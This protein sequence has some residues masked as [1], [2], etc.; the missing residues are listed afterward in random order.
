MTSGQSIRYLISEPYAL[1]GWKRLPYAVQNLHTTETRF[2]GKEAFEL[3]SS[4]NGIFPMEPQTLENW[5]KHT[6]EEWLESGLIRRAEP[7]EMLA[8]EQEYRFFPARFKEAVHWSVTGRCNYRCRHCFM[9]APHA[10][11]GEPSFEDCMRMLESFQR[12]GIRAI[13]LTGG[14][15]L[16]RRDFWQLVDEI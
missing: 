12:C 5:E 8:P 3:L 11:Q 2:M 15:P 10:V 14:E 7:G 1:R 4:C 13:H 9:S 6:L 16:V